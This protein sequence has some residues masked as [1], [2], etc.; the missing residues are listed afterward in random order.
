MRWFNDLEQMSTSADTAI[1]LLH[2]VGDI[3][4][5]REARPQLEAVSTASTCCE[6]TPEPLRE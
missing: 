4:I 6:A 2:V 3:G 5:S 1:R